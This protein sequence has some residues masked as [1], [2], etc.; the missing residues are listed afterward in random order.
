MEMSSLS[1][2]VELAAF[3]AR[4]PRWRPG[5][6]R[7]GERALHSEI[8]AASTEA[9]GPACALALALDDL[10]HAGGGQVE[11][12]PFMWVQDAASIR[13]T[14]RPCRAGL[15]RALRHRVIHVA[16]ACVEDA[17]FA[18]EEGMRCR[19]LAFVVGELTGNPRAVDFTASRRFTLAA[20]RHGVP[21][22][23]VRHDAAREL[24]SA[25]MRWQVRSAASARPLWDMDAPGTPAWHA[26][27]FRARAHTP[28]EWILSDDGRSL[29][30]QGPRT[31]PAAATPDHG[32]L[33]GAAGA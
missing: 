20:E 12:K 7:Q 29:A 24:S 8:F 5:L 18:L 28:G 2:A 33:A 14:G 11:E 6:A 19:D 25:R 1:R 27:L 9:A 32:D 3:G 15:P 21:L 16:A 17:L 30:A 22:F 4:A 13:L 31:D 23:L 10:R 26:E